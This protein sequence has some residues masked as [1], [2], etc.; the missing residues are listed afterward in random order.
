MTF[1]KNN[2]KIES[3]ECIFIYADRRNMSSDSTVFFE[4]KEELNSLIQRARGGSVDALGLL[5]SKYYPLIESQ[6]NKYFADYMSNQDRQD[7]YEDAIS[8]FCYAVCNYN[9]EDE[10]VEFGLYAKICISNRLVTFIRAYNSRKIPGVSSLDEMQEYIGTESGDPLDDV[11]QSESVRMLVNTIEKKLS[12]YEAKIW[13]LYASGMSA[14]EICEKVGAQDVRS[15]NNAIYRI[16]R[17]LRRL[18]GE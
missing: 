8:A 11:V 4:S 6:V 13:W 2:D 16:R 17:K 18:I 3:A 15:V 7:M 9:C 12:P 1:G 14:K 5:K 10:H